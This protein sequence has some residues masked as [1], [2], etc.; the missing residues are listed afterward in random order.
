MNLLELSITHRLQ[1]LFT[2][3]RPPVNI[4][5]L[6]QTAYGTCHP[7]FCTN[8]MFFTVVWFEVLT[9]VVIKSSILWDIT[10]SSPLEVNRRFGGTCRLH[11]QGWRISLLYVGFLFGLFFVPE[12]GGD[13]LLRN[14]GCLSAEYTALYYPR[15]QDSLSHFAHSIW[16]AKDHCHSYCIRNV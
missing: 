2:S 1:F 11:L 5:T 14:V 15:R 6:L 7:L 3:L 9:A 12:D 13:M 4:R 16:Q 10:P 8:P